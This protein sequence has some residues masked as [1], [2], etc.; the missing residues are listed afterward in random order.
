[1]G[2]IEFR[3]YK[4]VFCF[5]DPT[6]NFEPTER[7]TEIRQDPLTE[8]TSHILDIQFQAEKPD[9][10]EI[11]KQ[12]RSGFNPFAADTREQ[13]T[14]RFL[15]GDV[16]E[17]RLAVGEAVV[18][19]NL[20]PRDRFSAVTILSDADYIPLT[21]FTQQVLD[22]AFSVDIAYLKCTRD[23][24]QELKHFSIN[25]NYMHLAG[26]SLIHPHHQLI[27]SPIPT[28]YLRDVEKGLK[29]YE[30]NY[31][32]D[33]VTI[34]EE[35]NERWIGRLDN[36]AW[37]TAYAPLGHLDIV[38]TFEGRRSLFELTREDLESLS[39]GLL[40]IFDFLDS[41]NFVS[42]NFALYGLE[43]IENYT[44]HCRLSPRFFLSNTL[45]NSEMNY[46]EVLH[47]DPLA[48]FSPE[49]YA[50]RVRSSLIEPG[51]SEA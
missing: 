40:R 26:A 4:Q 25:W 1:M 33:L 6:Q 38:G 48:Y 7:V 41:E 9:V 2:K 37:I 49:A 34:E 46:F 22:D 20:F 28:N 21:G 16:P 24:D 3:A 50:H 31:F 23:K 17:G 32:K 18:I 47:N 36:V 35:R 10:E 5:Y 13:A 44:V 39:Q 8:R 30:G 12:A 45:M 15:E 19:P 29:K 43:D 14:P 27:A 11:V 51:H 42:F